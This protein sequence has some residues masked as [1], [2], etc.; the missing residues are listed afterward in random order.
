MGDI[1]KFNDRDNAL[2]QIHAMRV[3]TKALCTNRYRAN[4]LMDDGNDLEDI[5]NLYP[6]TTNE[7]WTVFL[8]YRDSDI[9]REDKEKFAKLWSQMVGSHNLGTHGYE[10][11]QPIWDK[12]DAMFSSQGQLSPFSNILIMLQMRRHCQPILRRNLAKNQSLL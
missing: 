6:S 9:H 11:K 8:D 2:S 1:F 10:R 4:K 12:H 5:S 3:F 7:E